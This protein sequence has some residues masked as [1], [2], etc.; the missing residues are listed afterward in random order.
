MNL[1]YR[2]LVGKGKQKQVAIVAVA[3]ELLGFIWSVAVEAEK[4]MKKAA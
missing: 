1:K 3:R 4:E 2:K